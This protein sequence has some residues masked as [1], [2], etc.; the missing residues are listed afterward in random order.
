M[1]V[2]GCQTD[3]DFIARAVDLVDDAGGYVG[4]LIFYDSHLPIKEKRNKRKRKEEDEGCWNEIENESTR[5][6]RVGS[7]FGRP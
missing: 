6:E 4:S 7:L 2:C 1:P 5:L 3:V